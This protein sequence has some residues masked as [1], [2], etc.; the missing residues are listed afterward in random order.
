MHGIVTRQSLRPD[1]SLAA[2]F[3][4]HQGHISKRYSCQRSGRHL[5]TGA[6]PLNPLGTHTSR[7][8]TSIPRNGTGILRGS[9]GHERRHME[10]RLQRLPAHAP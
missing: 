1:Q 6:R 5:L 7:C 10:R 9:L 3:V 2:K 8:G 4:A